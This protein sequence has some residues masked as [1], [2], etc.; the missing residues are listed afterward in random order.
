MCN[1]RCPGPLD[2]SMTKYQV[3]FS[4]C[5]QG[6][7]N[8][9]CNNVALLV[10]VSVSVSVSE[11]YFILVVAPSY[12]L[13][14]CSFCSRNLFGTCHAKFIM[15]FHSS[16]QDGQWIHALS[17]VDLIYHWVMKGSWYHSDCNKIIHQWYLSQLTLLIGSSL[18]CLRTVCAAGS[19]NDDRAHSETYVSVLVCIVCCS[20]FDIASSNQSLKLPLQ[21]EQWHPR[22]L[23]SSI[24]IVI[25]EKSCYSTN[26]TSCHLSIQEHQSQPMNWWLHFFNGWRNSIEDANFVCVIFKLMFVMDQGAL[27]TETILASKCDEAEKK[28]GNEDSGF[29]FDY[30]S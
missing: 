13:C 26:D 1:H 27:F 22:Q 25:D 17:W 30:L 7:L 10:S 19:H 20:F 16:I 14:F 6:D 8:L 28:H 3:S 2:Q 9:S 11:S 23:Q 15:L 18:Y 4:S 12:S 5:R 24:S 21:D 29:I